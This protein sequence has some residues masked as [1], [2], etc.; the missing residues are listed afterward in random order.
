[1][2][3]KY[4]K[5]MIVKRIEDNK[6]ITYHELGELYITLKEGKEETQKFLKS[7]KNL[8]EANEKAKEFNQEFIEHGFGC[9]IAEVN[10][11]RKEHMVVNKKG[12]R[13]YIRKKPYKE[14]TTVWLIYLAPDG[15]EYQIGENHTVGNKI[16]AINGL[17]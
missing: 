10:P 9:V 17:D 1:M 7:A 14:G 12:G 8:N 3:G 5:C 6:L 2:S 11:P 4:Y 13:P 15:R 16:Q